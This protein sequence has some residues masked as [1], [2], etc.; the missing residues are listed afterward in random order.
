MGM[1]NYRSIIS[2]QIRQKFNFHIS[3]LISVQNEKYLRISNF[4]IDTIVCYHMF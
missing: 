4:Y 2:V 3:G 1:M